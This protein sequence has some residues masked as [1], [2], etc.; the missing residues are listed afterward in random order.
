MSD[1]W[2]IDEKNRTITHV[3]NRIVFKWTITADGRAVLAHVNHGI[4]NDEY[5]SLLKDAERVAAEG[6][7]STENKEGFKNTLN[8]REQHKPINRLKARRE[9]GLRKFVFDELREN[10]YPRPASTGA[11]SDEES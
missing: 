7:L 10:Y 4:G 11:I 3:D 9:R 5:I 6:V 2:R 8:Y 1:K